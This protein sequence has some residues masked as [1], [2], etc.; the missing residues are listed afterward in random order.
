MVWLV[1]YQCSF[2]FR[3]CFI[4]FWFLF[5]LNNLC[6][7][8]KWVLVCHFPSHAVWKAVLM[9]PR[10]NPR[11]MGRIFHLKPTGNNKL[12]NVSGGLQLKSGIP[13]AALKPDFQCWVKWTRCGSENQGPRILLLPLEQFLTTAA[14]PP[15]HMLVCCGA[16]CPLGPRMSG[17]SISDSTQ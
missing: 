12:W 16:G 7:W 3:S 5:S 14:D 2:S 4:T 11:L 8:A 15:G 17:S 9:K 10:R 1:V 13:S 6:R